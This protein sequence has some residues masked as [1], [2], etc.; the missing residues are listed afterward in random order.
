MDAGLH[1]DARLG[2]W[3]RSGSPRAAKVA[4][5]VEALAA[6]CAEIAAIIARGA[7]DQALYAPTGR[8]SGIDEQKRLD[9]LANDALVA[10]LSRAPVAAI[11]SEELEAPLPLAAGAP[12][13]V[14]LDP[15]DGSSNI[16]A[17][18]SIGTIFSIL[19]SPPGEEAGVAFCQPGSGQLAAGFAV[20]GPQTTLTLTLGAGT[21]L[22]VLDPASRRFVLTQS[23]VAIPPHAREYAINT[24]NYR[25]WDPVVRTYVNDCMLGED[26]PRG[27]DFNMRWTASPVADV[28]RILARG[29]VFLYPG[30]RRQGYEHGRLRLLYEASPIAFLVEQAGGAASTGERR[31]LDIVPNDLHERVPVVL[32]SRAE[33]AYVERLHREP[34]LRERSPLFSRRGLLRDW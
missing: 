19:P 18:V 21:E 14:A 24:S 15:I 2:E 30:D 17:N 3:A 28:Q 8:R 20:Y 12:L 11:A 22:Y 9:V 31:I 1:L 32:G 4:A 34:H 27:E 16:E 7:L 10:A 26:G 29:G 13:L 6:A 23:R 5:A 25:H 33:V